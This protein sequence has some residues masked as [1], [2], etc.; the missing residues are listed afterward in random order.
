MAL[1]LGDVDVASIAS[2]PMAVDAMESVF[3]LEGSGRVG[4]PQRVDV[5]TGNGWLRLMPVVVE[6]LGLFGYKAMNLVPKVGVRY[7]L[8]LYDLASGTLEGIVDAQLITALRTA[9]TSAVATRRLASPLVEQVAVIGTGTE[10]RTQVEAMALIRSPKAFRVHSRSPENRARF[11]ADMRDR[12]AA[13]MVDCATVDEA[14]D[15]ADVV[16]LATKSSSPVLLARHLR[17]GLHVSSIGSARLDQFELAPEAF[18]RFD[19]VVCDSV[20]HVAGE[21]GDAAAAV[22][23]GHWHPEMA[24][25]LGDLLVEPV[26]RAEGAVTLFKSVGTATQDV[27]LGAEVLSAA[28]QKGLGVE[29]PDFPK[30]K[31]LGP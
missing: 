13:E 8:H 25:D 5:P 22:E 23:Q 9:A 4:R 19:L 31:P 3:L 10:A 24:L 15:G 20:E 1:I 29:L 6:G 21:A 7:V 30:R 16:V 27:A 26:A 28:R 12:V 2:L 11:I 18:A 14:V 17:P